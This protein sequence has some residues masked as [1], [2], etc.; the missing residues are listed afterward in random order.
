MITH[1]RAKHF[2]S[3]DKV[4]SSLNPQAVGVVS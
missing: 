3:A 4:F 2:L 1:E